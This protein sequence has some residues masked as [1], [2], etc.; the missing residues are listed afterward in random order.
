MNL[1]NLAIGQ[2]QTNTI[3]IKAVVID[4]SN[5]ETMPFVSIHKT[6][7]KKG[8]LSDF[9]GKFILDKVLP[10]DTIIISYI[11]YE[12][13]LIIVN[14]HTDYDTIFLNPQIQL[15]DEVI[16]LADNSMLYDVVSNARKTQSNTTETAK[17]YFELE[18]YCN[19]RQ[20]ELFQGYYNGTYQGYNVS[21]LKM[22]N[23]RFALAPLSKRIFAST[24]SSK[25]LYM[26]NLV[27]SNNYFPKSPFEFNRRKLKKY[28]ALV[29]NA[30]YKDDDGKTTYVIS[31]TPRSEP[32][33]FFSGKVW[34]DS[35]SNNILKIE[36]SVLN[37]SIHPFRPIWSTH[38]LDTV[39]IQITKSFNLEN[40]GIRLNT[41]DFNYDLIY[42]SLNDSSLNISSQAV[43][44][45]YNYNDAFILPYF[46]FPITSNAD[47]R[48]I[49][50]LP[51]NEQF[52]NCADEFTIENDETKN[53]FINDRSTIRASDL[54][55]S[56]TLFKKNFFENPFVVWNR[57]RI[58][59]KGLSADSSKYYDE[60]RTMYA[61]RYNLKVQFL[62]DINTVCD[63]IQLV[64]KTIFD[65]YVSFYLFETTRESQAFLNIYFDLM[66]VER[67]KLKIEL[68]KVK[69]VPESIEQVYND[70]VD[71]AN[72]LSDSYFKEVQRGTNREALQKWNN[73]VFKALNIDNIEFFAIEMN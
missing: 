48:Q 18:S 71:R 38:T 15:I 37:A 64:T 5:L 40:N 60:Q 9:K 65:P 4:S 43:L 73:V 20:L 33:S 66:E 3:S 14:E 30:R 17:S 27:E 68:E 45:A 54:F 57:N 32:N 42:R 41:I 34:I 52:W 12:K 35:V 36:L 29:L 70:A 23:G 7:D 19:E 28:F 39:N 61:N 10:N 24:E 6:R 16:V 56:D 53:A 51:Y 55:S 69:N 31:F 25:A 49:Q 59:I 8:T 72:Q 44:H 1:F 62:V 11:G 67:R 46:N 50:M 58:I 63:S 21:D 26:H 13:T 47:Y 2:V 22:K